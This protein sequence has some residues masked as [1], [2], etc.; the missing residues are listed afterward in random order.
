VVSPPRR[1]TDN[2][3]MLEDRARAA[4]LA[5]TFGEHLAASVRGLPCA[6]PVAVETGPYPDF[7]A[8]FHRHRSH[9]CPT[10]STTRWG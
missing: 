6:P 3:P 2:P 7:T 5:M 10:S 9:T 8:T 4:S 1:L